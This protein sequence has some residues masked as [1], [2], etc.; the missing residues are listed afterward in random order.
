MIVVLC[1]RK[2]AYALPQAP[3]VSSLEICE[4]PDVPKFPSN[5]EYEKVDIE[6]NSIKK[7]TKKYSPVDSEPKNIIDCVTFSDTLAFTGEPICRLD[8]KYFA[9]G[10]SVIVMQDGCKHIFHTK[11]YNKWI[12]EN[13]GSHKCP[14]CPV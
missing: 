14:N 1:R 3:D 2:R 7:H 4:K 10:E 11:C 8:N 6:I 5:F 9:E 12:I 13:K